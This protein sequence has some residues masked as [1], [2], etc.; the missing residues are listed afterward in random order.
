[1]TAQTEIAPCQHCGGKPQFK[2]SSAHVYNGQNYGP[3]WECSCGARCG[4]HKGTNRPLGTVCDEPTRQARKSAH[5]A[6]D[7]LWKHRHPEFRNFMYTRLAELMGL[8]KD[9]CHIGSMNAEQCREVV[10]IV[11]TGE[12]E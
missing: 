5:A 12:L 3:I 6:F 7:P 10:E 11:R 1:M 2:P 8:T 4:C 9:E